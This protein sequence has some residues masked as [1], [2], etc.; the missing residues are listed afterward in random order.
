MTNW[1]EIQAEMDGNERANVTYTN[2]VE[3]QYCGDRFSHGDTQGLNNHWRECKQHPAQAEITRL[4]AANAR[5][6]AACE[7]ALEAGWLSALVME[8]IRAA[9]DYAKSG[10]EQTGPRLPGLE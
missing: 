5:L 6:L 2:F 7:A 4:K 8:Q 10:P 3:C 1:A 9:V